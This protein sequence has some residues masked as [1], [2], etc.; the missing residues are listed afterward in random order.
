M[1][2]PTLRLK[3]C[4][5]LLSVNRIRPYNIIVSFWCLPRRFR[6]LGAVGFG[7]FV[8][9]LLAYGRLAAKWP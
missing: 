1:L 4:R 5:L 3:S 2:R 8:S 9:F 7:G 6:R